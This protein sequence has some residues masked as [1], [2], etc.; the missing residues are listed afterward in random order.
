MLEKMGAMRNAYGEALVELGASNPRVVVLGAD[1]TDSMKSGMFGAKY[2][3]RFFNLG[4]AEQNLVGVAA[5]LAFGGK[6]AFAGTYAIFVPGKCVD[7]IRNMLCYADLNVK[8]VCSHAGITVGPDGGSHE[9]VE[10]IAL[11]RCVPH[12]RVVVPAD[13][14]AVK[15]IVKAIADIP[16]PFYVRLTRG[17]VKGSNTPIVYEEGFEYKLG[18]ANVIREGNDVA[19]FGCG[20][21]LPEAVRAAESLA[22][23]GIS[24]SVIDIHTVKPIDQETI[25]NY[26]K[27]CG[28]AVSAE[29]HNIQGG[30]GSAVAEVLTDR[31]PI[32][33]KRVGVNDTFGESGEAQELL[34]KYGLTSAHIESAARE[35]IAMKR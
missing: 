9:Q 13:A 24:A 3:D 18:K 28:C 4:I 2:A 21:M 29:E 10:D 14:V 11:M 23:Q 7:Q 16:G 33:L 6:I 22:K 34:N 12:M 25:I 20:I 19:L 17:V 30:M 8:L 35:A 5:G 32:P 31:Y 15:G 26:A 27:R 1:T